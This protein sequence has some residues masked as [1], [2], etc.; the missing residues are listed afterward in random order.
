M[1][2]QSFA[3][4]ARIAVFVSAL[5]GLLSA[6]A[7][8]RQPIIDNIR[9]D[10][11]PAETLDGNYLA[12]I[13]A[14]ASRNTAAAAVFF[15]EA[16]KEDPRNADLRERAFV[17]FLANGSMPDALSAAREIAR[18]DRNNG[19]A[20]LVLGVE[21][22]KNRR[23][24][25]ARRF[26]ER[27]GRGPS[28]DITATLLSAWSWA[29]SKNFSEAVGT[30][31]RLEGEIAY[32]IFRN[33]HAGLIAAMLGS[34]RQGEER[35]RAAH[36]AERTTLRVVEAYA[37]ILSARGNQKEAAAVL[38]A[39]D[40]LLPR[41]P[42]IRRAQ[43]DIAA[44]IKLKPLVQTPQQGA[45]EVLYGLGAA[46]NGQGD[47]IAALI[48]LRLALF[49]DPTHA[50]AS[51]TLGDVLLRLEQREEAIAVL[52][53]IPT[54]SPLYTPASIQIAIALDALERHDDAIAY[55]KGILK[56]SPDDIEVLT[57]LGSLQRTRKQFA[58]S[59]ETYDRAISL[60]GEP[61]ASHW[62][63]FYF[64]GIAY[65][66]SKQWPKAEAD[67]KKALELAPET[68]GSDRAIILNYLAYSW[69]DRG[70][71]LTEALDML[72]R[73]VELK[74]R[75]GYIVD[76]LAWAYYRLG[77]YEDAVRDLEKAIELRPADP[78]INDHLGD[79]Y[80]RVGR[81]IEARF[82]WNHAR[83]LKPEPEELPKILEKIKNGLPDAPADRK[84]EAKDTKDN[85]TAPQ[86]TPT[87][88]PESSRAPSVEEPADDGA[89][90]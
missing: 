66:R 60:I 15:R 10:Y 74:P 40:E 85:A 55:L 12:A 86:K 84:A 76:S 81:K 87:P 48:Y 4:A 65:E 83:D 28:A 2:C 53:T 90:E 49:L 39:F 67:L 59:A 89:H 72:Q 80:W 54:T 69:V 21:A 20:Q 41:H 78:A 46:G 8:A 9:P 1:I 50:L 17:A 32:N 3:R 82:Q 34:T 18:V 16:L 25:N 36:E 77:R 37:R 62:T 61:D 11:T 31:D 45:A 70:E 38:A 23:Y 43:A 52:G 5:S 19:L 63:L 44:G 71:N 79:A 22:L 6:P 30:V 26:F 24:V 56:T 14:G 73:A 51:L 29:G 68:I 13:I 27:G 35:L 88:Q 47:E 42:I 75:D 58:E 7:M 33:Y 57:G 64:R